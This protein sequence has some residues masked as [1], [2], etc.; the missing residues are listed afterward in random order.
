MTTR[1]TNDRVDRPRSSDPTREAGTVTKIERP[2]GFALI[3]GDNGEEYFVHRNFARHEFDRL[4]LDARVT[5]VPR[6]SPKGRRAHDLR[7]L[8][9]GRYVS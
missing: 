3:R 2:R 9:E 4:G 8:E 6:D 5:F 7:V 1:M